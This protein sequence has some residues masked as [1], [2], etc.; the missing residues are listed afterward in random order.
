[1]GKRSNPPQRIAGVLNL[2]KPAGCTSRDIVNRVQRVFG[3]HIRVG[4]AGT[5]DPMATGVLLI[6][7]GRATKLMPVIHE[8][9]KS[10]RAD[11]TLGCSSDTDDA[12]GNI[13]KWD[14]AE[15]PSLEQVR[16]HLQTQIGEIM[17]VP[18]AYSAV[19]L[20][21]RRAYDMARKGEPT[22][23]LPR[24]VTIF[25]IDVLDYRYPHL[26]L[27][28]RCGSGTYIRSI[29]RDLGEALATGGLMHDLSRT[30]IGPFELAESR[31]IDEWEASILEGAD[32]LATCGNVEILF[33][34]WD[35]YVLSDV[36]TENLSHGRPL[37]VQHTSD[38]LAACTRQG[39]FVAILE[40]RKENQFKATLNWLP[41]MT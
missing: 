24:K 38:R 5:L 26:N 1:M 19:K 21:G 37:E 15:I 41:T 7:V 6:C 3:R 33:E 39:K 32:P 4:H 40:R 12:T 22:E 16:K 17:Q 23:I 30:R 36:D 20:Q 28:V 2:S 18:P 35:Q 27:A 13:R 29:A 31:P 9:C 8:F 34:T 11:F 14:V 10:Y 25:D